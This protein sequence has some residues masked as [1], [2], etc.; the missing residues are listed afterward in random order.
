MLAHL[1]AQ[2]LTADLD[3]LDDAALRRQ[4]GSRQHDE[5]FAQGRAP[6]VQHADLPVRILL[7]QFLGHQPHAP[8]G[9]ADAA[10][11]ADVQHIVAVFQ[12]RLH[13]PPGGVRC[14][15]GGLHHGAVPHGLVKAAAI[16]LRADIRRLT[17]YGVGQAKLTDAVLL[18]QVLGQ[19]CRVVGHNT[20]HNSVLLFAFAY[21]A[22]CGTTHWASVSNSCR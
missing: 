1:A 13:F 19:V 4:L 17:V 8:A 5:T 21:Y 3:L 7:G 18:Q 22:S 11:E 10:G 9:T 20:Y 15:H 6:A 14:N 12:M 2:L 16:E